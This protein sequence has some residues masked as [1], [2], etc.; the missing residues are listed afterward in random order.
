MTRIEST[1]SCIARLANV[2]ASA[3]VFLALAGGAGIVSAQQAAPPQPT[4]AVQLAGV[5]VAA[6]ENAF[7]I[8]EYVATTRG[9]GGSQTAACVAVYDELKARKFGGDFDRLVQWWQDNRVAAFERL[10]AGN[11]GR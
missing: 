11:A 2:A 8:C 1:Q 5:D 3:A 7:W 9:T 10:G 4:L 6:L